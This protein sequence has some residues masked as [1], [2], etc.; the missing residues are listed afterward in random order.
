MVARGSPKPL[1]WVRILLPLPLI[2]CLSWA[3]F[4]FLKIEN[5]NKNQEKH[6]EE[7]K[8][9]EKNALFWMSISNNGVKSMFFELYGRKKGRNLFLLKNNDKFNSTFY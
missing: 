2:Y 6:G 4:L 9:E 7:E 5:V 1:V 3:I 8:K